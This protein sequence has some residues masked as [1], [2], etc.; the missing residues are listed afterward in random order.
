MKI[1]SV[2]SICLLL[3][4]CGGGQGI[5][6]TTHPLEIDLAKTADP[7][8]VTML[9]VQFKVVN[10]D[11]LESFLSELR[12]N[13]GGNNPV[14]FAI[15]TRDYENMALNV[16]DLRRYIEQQQS[17]IVYYRTLTSKYNEQAQSTAPKK[18]E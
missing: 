6:V 12:T 13:Q 2:I 16:A 10:K 3:V 14:F 4:A 7:N 1:L 15:S 11:N 5:T 17:I 9:P 8:G 18:S